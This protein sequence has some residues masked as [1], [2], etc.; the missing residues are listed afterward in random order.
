MLKPFWISKKNNYEKERRKEGAFD[1]RESEDNIDENQNQ[2]LYVQWHFRKNRR[3]VS[4]FP[5]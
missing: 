3:N 2:E 5:L 4:C 1:V